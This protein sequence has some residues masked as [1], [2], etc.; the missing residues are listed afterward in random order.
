MMNEVER[1]ESSKTTDRKP[2]ASSEESGE[3]ES[4]TAEETESATIEET[5]KATTEEVVA[6]AE[7]A[8]DAEK[9][10]TEAGVE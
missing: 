3:T 2:A 1:E 5:E 8:D 7:S 6:E 10:A 9:V 4:A